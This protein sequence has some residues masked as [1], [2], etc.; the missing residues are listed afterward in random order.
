MCDFVWEAKNMLLNRKFPNY[1]QSKF[2]VYRQRKY[3]LYFDKQ[4][5]QMNRI[6]TIKKKLKKHDEE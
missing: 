3:T 4:K 5:Q 2:C 6:D 1:I